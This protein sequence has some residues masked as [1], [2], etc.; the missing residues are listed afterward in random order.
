MARVYRP[1]CKVDTT[2][3]LSGVQGSLKSTILA[4][5]AVREEWF[6]DSTIDFRSK[7]AYQLLPGVWIYELAELEALRGVHASTL[8]AFLSSRRDRYRPSYGRNT[9]VTPRQTVFLGSTNDAEFLSDPTGSRRFWP[10]RVGKPNLAALE[11]DRD[12]IWAEAAHLFKAGTQWW[13]DPGAERDLRRHSEAFRQ[14]DAWEPVVED[15]LAQQAARP[16]TVA[17]IVEGALHKKAADIR[18]EDTMRV[19]TI[20]VRLGF[21]KERTTVRGRR[22][23]R[24]KRS[25]RARS[26]PGSKDE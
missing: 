25:G 21:E 24:W 19:G 22:S 16:L 6:S 3:M 1:G 12:Q 18:P 4:A 9:V 15:W 7:D 5:L 8:K 2:L 23:T 26:A 13:L 10:V 20:L 11:R 14:V 17:E